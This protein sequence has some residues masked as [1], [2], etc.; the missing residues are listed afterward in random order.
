MPVIIENDFDLLQ[1]GLMTVQNPG[2][3]LHLQYLSGAAHI[4]F[5]AK[6]AL[7]ATQGVTVGHLTMSYTG[8]VNS[9]GSQVGLACLQ[10]GRSL[11]GGTAYV[12]LYQPS[13]GFSS[14]YKNTSG[15]GT[16]IFLTSVSGTP[17]YGSLS[18]LWVVSPDL[19]WTLLIASVGGEERL[20]YQDFVA[21]Y[22]SGVTESGFFW[23]TS[24]IAYDL[25]ITSVAM[26][27]P[28]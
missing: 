16:A 3:G 23:D 15:L 8:T 27:G 18:L 17:S 7:V 6:L 24:T 2:A 14:L 4:N 21:P 26:Y 25:T 5:P 9:S 10:S 13:T 11:V 28:P 19:D 12:F 1:N 22:T 20:R